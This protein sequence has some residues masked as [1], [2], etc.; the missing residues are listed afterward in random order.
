M[1]WL[2]TASKDVH[3]R[4]PSCLMN[5]KDISI[6]TPEGENALGRIIV[7]YD[8][9]ANTKHYSLAID[10]QSPSPTLLDFA[11]NQAESLESGVHIEGGN[12]NHGEPITTASKLIWST[13]VYVYARS[14]TGLEDWDKHSKNLGITIRLID[15]AVRQRFG[16]AKRPDVFICHDS[17]DKESIARPL[18]IRLREQGLKVW[19]DEFSIAIGDSIDD[20]MMKGIKGSRKG[21][22]IVS[23]N[24]ISN[25]KD[26]RREAQSW[27]AEENRRSEYLLLPVWHGVDSEAVADWI[28]WLAR[29]NAAK[30]PDENI[31]T[32]SKKIHKALQSR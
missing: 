31:E 17:K 10:T 9:R 22:L 5:H 4:F 24:L 16:E 14:I 32:I 11:I 2:E 29:R 13:V 12:P 1:D 21:V 30:S 25:H 3:G 18:A 20:A 6:R 19:F 27:I 15:D 23:Q 26:A 8:F 7:L 28:P